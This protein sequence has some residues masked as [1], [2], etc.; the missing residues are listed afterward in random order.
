MMAFVQIFVT[1]LHGLG[2][3][4]DDASVVCF[5]AMGVALWSLYQ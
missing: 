5:P 1:S 3:I 4:I 2:A